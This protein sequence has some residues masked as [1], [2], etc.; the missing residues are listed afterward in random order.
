MLT[1]FL[2]SVGNLLRDWTGNTSSRTLQVPKFLLSTHVS[3]DKR[4]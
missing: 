1:M 2:Y 4:W 3:W